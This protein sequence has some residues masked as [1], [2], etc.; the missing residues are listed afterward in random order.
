MRQRRG[1]LLPTVVTRYLQV[2]FLKGGGEG[3][4]ASADGVFQRSKIGRESPLCVFAFFFV[5]FFHL[6]SY[7]AWL[8]LR[9]PP[10]IPNHTSPKRDVGVRKAHV[11]DK[12]QLVVGAL[13]DIPPTFHFFS[14][15]ARRQMAA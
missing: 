3:C 7:W 1:P 11:L 15:V 8:L 12:L 4:E 9:H 10:F 2:F 6:S 14:F 13:S 5:F